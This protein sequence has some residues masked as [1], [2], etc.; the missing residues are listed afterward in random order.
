MKDKLLEHDLR[1]VDDIAR[2]I[3]KLYYG[4]R[5]DGTDGVRYWLWLHPYSRSGT[6]DA[7]FAELC[8]ALL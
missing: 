5:P 2:D 6:V 3:A 7:L 4:T 8:E 1:S